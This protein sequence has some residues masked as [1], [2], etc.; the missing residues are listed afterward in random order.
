MQRYQLLST[1]HRQS[2]FIGTFRAEQTQYPDDGG[3]KYH[4]RGT[5]H[6]PLLYIRKQPSNSVSG[7]VDCKDDKSNRIFFALFA[8]LYISLYLL[9]KYH[10]IVKNLSQHLLFFVPLLL[11]LTGMDAVTRL[12][13]LKEREAEVPV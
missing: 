12:R 6:R 7:Y 8:L 10:K 9:K 1:F 13:Y 4:G 5:N 3:T 11:R 2:G